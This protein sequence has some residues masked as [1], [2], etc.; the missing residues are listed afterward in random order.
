MSHVK[1]MIQQL[2]QDAQR[3]TRELGAFSSAQ[4]NAILAAM[5]DG[6]RRESATLLAANARDLDAGRAVGLSPALLD[7]LALDPQRIEDMALG[8]EQVSQLPDPVG[9]VIEAFERPNGLKISR[10]RVPIGVIGIIYESRPNV[11]ADAGALCLKAGNAVILRGGK[12][13]LHSNMAIAD[14]LITAGQ[15]AGMP[16]GAL[17]L[18]RTP[19]RDAVRELVQA[20]GLVDL[21]IPRG[22]EGLIEAVTRMAYVP[23]IKHYK[24]VCHTYVDASADLEMALAISENAK[25]QRPGVCNAMETLLVHEAVAEDFV[26]RMAAQLE[27]A[28][29]E[30]RGDARFCELWPNAKEATEEDWPAEYLDLI[31][32]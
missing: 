17:Q 22:G 24:G 2:A 6:L 14:V 4:K 16:P 20:S 25:V 1:Q 10:V 9:E 28:G 31:L 29:V 26:P 21:I 27:E 7:R 32:A 8:L 3:A 11:T 19:D 12:E 23:V 13:S 15:E 5:A 18:V 30:L